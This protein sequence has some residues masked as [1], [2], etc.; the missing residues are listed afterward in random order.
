MHGVL[1]LDWLQYDRAPAVARATGGAQNLS[2]DELNI[3]EA[4]LNL[5]RICGNRLLKAIHSCAAGGGTPP[6]FKTVPQ[7]HQA[8]LGLDEVSHARSLPAARCCGSLVP[9]CPH[10]SVARRARPARSDGSRFL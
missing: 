7:A 3:A 8:L 1:L 10:R 2:Q 6:R 4:V 9:A 5:S